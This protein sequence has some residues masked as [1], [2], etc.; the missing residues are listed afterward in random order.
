MS[1]LSNAL[2]LSALCAALA[3]PTAASAADR[4]GSTGRE[5]FFATQWRGWKAPSED[6]VYIRAGPKDVF[7]VELSAGSRRLTQSG[8]FLQ[9]IVRG[10]NAICSAADLDLVLADTGGYWQPLIARSMRKLTAEEVEAIPRK[11]RP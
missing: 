8:Y 7:R 4:D 10:N 2:K 6:V 1:K 3:L 11:L 9:N 5:C